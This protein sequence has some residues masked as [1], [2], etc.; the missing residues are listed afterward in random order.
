M[1]AKQTNCSGCYYNQPNQ[2]AHMN[3]NGCL[4][5]YDDIIGGIEKYMFTNDFIDKLTVKESTNDEIKIKENVTVKESK[6]QKNSHTKSERAKYF[7]PSEKDKLFWCFY[8]ILNGFESYQLNRHSAFKTEKDEKFLLVENINKLK[9]QLKEKNIKVS[10]VKDELSNSSCIT[11]KGLYTLCIYHE[12]NLIYVYNKTFYDI[13]VCD[14]KPYRVI[15]NDKKNI[16]IP[17]DVNEEELINY[18]N[19]FL[20]IHHI[21]K[22]IL[23]ITAYTLQQLKEMATKLDLVFE[24]KSPTKKDIYERVIQEIM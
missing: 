10:D 17:Y 11:V 21:N 3:T 9:Q 12:I 8:I 2:L 24:K 7:Y 20:Q 16:F 23:S 5:N 15:I 1:Q 18:K 22:P 13:N 6:Q 19:N 14:S 4:S